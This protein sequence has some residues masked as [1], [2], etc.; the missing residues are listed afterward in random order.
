MAVLLLV[1]QC[2]AQR[3]PV[4]AKNTK[5]QEQMSFVISHPYHLCIEKASQEKVN[6]LF[7]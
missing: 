1:A 7:P 2:L 5:L 4:Q 3:P 6:S